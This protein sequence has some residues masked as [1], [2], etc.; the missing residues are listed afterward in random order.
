MRNG[1]REVTF[2]ARHSHNSTVIAVT[3]DVVGS[4]LADQASV[5][6][7][8]IVSVGNHPV[9][10]STLGF[11]VSFTQTDQP[12]ILRLKPV[13]YAYSS[14]DD[15]EWLSPGADQKLVIAPDPTF[16]PTV[17]ASTDEELM[18]LDMLKSH[19][20]WLKK[21]LQLQQE[22]IVS[23]WK[24][25]FAMCSS[26][27]CYLKT[28]VSKAPVFAHLIADRFR[29]KSHDA[30]EFVAKHLKCPESHEQLV[31][32]LD[33]SEVAHVDLDEFDHAAKADVTE[34]AYS[35]STLASRSA[36]S[37]LPTPTGSP[38]SSASSEETEA[39]SP[40]GH[41]GRPPWAGHHRP[42]WAKPGGRPPW[43]DGPPPWAKPGGRPPWGDGPPPWAKSGDGEHGSR[44]S[45]SDVG[46]LTSDTQSQNNVTRDMAQD[47]QP[48]APILTPQQM[49]RIRLIGASIGILVVVLL[50]AC[51]FTCI[52]HKTKIFRDPRRRVEMKAAREEWKNKRAYR[53][54]ARKH[55]WRKFV[56]SIIPMRKSD[57]EEKQELM[58]GQDTLVVNQEINNLRAATELVGQM[59]KAEEGESGF[60]VPISPTISHSESLPSYSS[61]PPGYASCQ[62]GDISVIDGFTNYTR[63]TITTDDT[64]DSSV[65]DCSP[66]MSFETQRTS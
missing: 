14:T 9:A 10:Q 26:L 60:T 33:T 2:P 15:V 30:A 8:D 1:Q 28:A 65:V 12:Q 5:V 41:E 16:P 50:A 64:P 57:E 11:T 38:A 17:P 49:W 61:A 66:R 56:R 47:T 3:A 51:I 42:P 25:E 22:S 19:F 39:S 13:P 40:S 6:S 52:K 63:S 23:I 27:K 36:G 37:S 24:S 35:T 55:K 21:E 31:T 46:S 20:E 54:A 62:E 34:V 53:K 43:G 7:L 45:V 32:Q 44:P 58:A 4:C 48:S 18:Q 59:M 29:Q